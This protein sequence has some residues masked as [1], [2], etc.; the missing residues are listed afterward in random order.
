M[1]EKANKDEKTN[2]EKVVVYSFE[3]KQYPALKFEPT[4]GSFER[5]SSGKFKTKNSKI[6]KFLRDYKGIAIKEIKEKK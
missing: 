2:E 5:F 3:C 6:A 1:A 4:K